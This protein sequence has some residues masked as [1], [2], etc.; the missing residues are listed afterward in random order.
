MPPSSSKTS[1]DVVERWAAPSPGAPLSLSSR[2][3]PELGPDDVLVEVEAAVVGAPEVRAL[4]EG[5]LLAPGGAAVGVAV[6]AGAAAAHRVGERILV[7]PVRPC[8]EC[9]V[10][11]RGHPA[12]CPARRRLGVDVDGALASHVVTSSRAA[13]GLAGPLA[14]AVPGPAAAL[15]AREAALAYE[16]VVRAGVAPGE[17][18]VWLGPGP[19]GRLGREI[20]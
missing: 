16:M 2:P 12:V 14:G 5:S 9:D 20:A 1:S 11:R 15:L 8:F 3:A 6:A 13:T 17:V 7:G 4:S 10:C 19:I 18:T